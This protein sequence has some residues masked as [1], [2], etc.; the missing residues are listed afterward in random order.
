MIA[1]ERRTK[2]HWRNWSEVEK[3]DSRFVSCE[4]VSRYRGA[5]RDYSDMWIVITYQNRDTEQH[6][7]LVTW[8]HT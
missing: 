8:R 7:F 3:Y 5:K 2:V 6:R 1:R 4:T